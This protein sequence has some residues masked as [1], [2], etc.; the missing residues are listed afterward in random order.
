MS[1]ERITI[2]LKKEL[3]DHL[4]KTIDGDSI[5]NRSHAIEHILSDTLLKK[6]LRVLILAG[7]KGVSFP[8]LLG[9]V[10]KALLRIGEKPLLEYTIEKLKASKLTD[11]VISIGQGGQKIK[12]Y[13]RSGNKWGVNISYLEQPAGKRGT[14]YP[15]RQAQHAFSDNTFL[16]LYGDVLTDINYFDILEFH[17]SQKS[18]VVT[19]ALTS[20]EHASLWGV[21]KLMGS[22]I[23]EF[24][25]KPKNPST[26]SHLVNAGVYVMEPEIFKFIGM[27]AS[28]L[29]RDVFPR[30][31]EESKLIGYPFEGVWYDVSNINVYKDVIR[32]F[33]K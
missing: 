29:E 28:K 19:M 11:I 15:L 2:T 5:R 13:F 12:D 6:P 7:G 20:V 32:E 23:I 3:L 10:P 18:P 31:A 4:D 1:R 30:L 9:E 25:E 17:Q 8:H 22:R 27:N 21:A 16:L 26:H 14:A 33:G 24:E